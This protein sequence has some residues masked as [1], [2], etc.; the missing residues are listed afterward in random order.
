M[1][2][3]QSRLEGAATKAGAAVAAGFFD[4]LHLGHKAVLESALN[5]AHQAGLEAWVFTFA[6]HPRVFLSPEGAPPLLSTT[7]TRL[8]AFEALGFDGVC[9]AEFDASI[10]ALP[11]DI[12]ADRLLLAFP[13]LKCVCC[14]SNWRFGRNAAGTPALLAELGAERGF[15]AEAAPVVIF[16][17][18]PVSSTRLRSA[19]AAGDLTAAAA[20]LGRPYSITGQVARGRHV[21]SAAGFATANIATDGLA[22]PPLGVYA[23]D[24]IVNGE[25]I[26]GVADLGWRPTFPDARP[27][28]PVLEVHLIGEK[29]DLYGE[30]IDIAFIKRL[31]DEIRFPSAEA[32]FRQVAADVAAASAL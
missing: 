9:L 25:A 16:D 11:P 1:K 31:R 4:G 24:A 23:V 20:M 30:T 10:A 6:T 21:A 17:N 7:A 13:G 29:R 18:A 3:V 5:A 32:L 14:G 15:R 27:D 22:I 2:V 19:V 28:A 12:F 26:R 8:K